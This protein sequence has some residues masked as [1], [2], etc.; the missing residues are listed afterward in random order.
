VKNTWPYRVDGELGRIEFPTYRVCQDDTTLYDTAREIFVPLGCWERYQT[1]GFKEIA[2][3][4]GVTEASYN[5]TA[6]FINRIRHQPDAT[7]STTLRASAEREGRQV[8]ECLERTTTTILDAEGFD[9]TQAS[10]SR[11]R[12]AGR[13]TR[14]SSPH[15]RSKTPSTPAS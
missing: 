11:R 12:R 7:G 3:I 8:L 9:A 4:R 14:W 13:T 15:S 2:F 1:A 10:P 6:I 5:K